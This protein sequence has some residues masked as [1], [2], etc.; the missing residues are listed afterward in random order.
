MPDDLIKTMQIGRGVKPVVENPK[1]PVMTEK[2]LR[3][4]LIGGKRLLMA[5]SPRPDTGKT[6]RMAAVRKTTARVAQPTLKKELSEMQEPKKAATGGGKEGY[7]RLRLRVSGDRVTVVGAK[8]VEGPLVQR[9]NIHGSLAY[10][11]T[12]GSK[13]VAAGSILDLGERRSFPNESPKAPPEQ[14]GH[15]IT[16]VPT[17]EVNVRVPASEV[18]MTALP[19][20]NVRLYRIKEDVDVRLAKPG[21]LGE[22]FPR[23]LREV[24]RVT[25]IKVADL[26]AAH[27]TELRKALG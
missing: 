16:E 21:P 1:L 13:R 20:L 27:R 17:Y 22:Q 15:F 12:L 3:P 4:R 26:P 5:D 24:A 11:V 6:G 19:R 9:P 8:A 23:E 18:S 25:G 14:R 2:A 7:V 10:D